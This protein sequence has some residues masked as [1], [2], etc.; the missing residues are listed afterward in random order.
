[1]PTDEHWISEALRRLD[2]DFR[3][4]RQ[5]MRDRLAGLETSF[6]RRVAESQEQV[7]MRV[8]ENKISVTNRVDLFDMKTT[9]LVNAL[10]TRV[11]ILESW[12]NYLTGAWVVVA[13]LLAAL[14]SE[15]RGLLA[16]LVK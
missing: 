7:L 4:H 15:L 13:A 16:R 8:E 9:Q 12:K 2:D 14:W 3:E 11:R 5:E 10:E 1:M 6:T